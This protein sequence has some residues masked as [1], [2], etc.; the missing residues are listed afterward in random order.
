MAIPYQPPYMTINYAYWSANWYGS[1]ARFFNR[2]MKEKV[3]Q[4]TFATSGWYGNR[5]FVA[6]VNFQKFFGLYV[7]GECGPQTWNLIAYLDA[8]T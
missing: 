8:N 4:N 6:C 2:F 1:A 7:D 3:G 5:S